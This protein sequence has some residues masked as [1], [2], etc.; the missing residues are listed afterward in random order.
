[1]IDIRY[2]TI[3]PMLDIL[4]AIQRQ[5]D[6]IEDIEQLLQHPDYQMEFD[7]YGKRVSKEDFKS[8]LMSG[9]ELSL[10]DRDNDDLKHHHTYYQHAMENL[11]ANRQAVKRLDDL[12]PAFLQQQV[13]IA[14]HGLPDGYSL[15]DLQCVFTVGIGQSFGYVHDRCVHFDFLQLVKDQ[16]ME[17]FLSSLAHELH[18]VGMLSLMHELDWN[19]LSLENQFYFYFSGEGLAVKYCNNAQGILSQNLHP[20]MPNVGLDPDS[21]TYLMDDFPHAFDRFIDTIRRIRGGDLCTHGDL[22]DE[23]NSYWH[24]P[25]VLDEHGEVQRFKHSRIYSMGNEIWGVI[26]DVFGKERVFEVLYDLDSFPDAYNQAVKRLDFHQY[27]IP[28]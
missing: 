16:S 18:H 21:W 6:V 4:Q 3:E 1:M 8:Y 14:R 9:L 15:G 12:T 17:T 23:L 28:E 5:Q 26:H 10:V 11:A 19:K 22:M 20:D 13:E 25:D 24:N 27:C 7:R 2:E